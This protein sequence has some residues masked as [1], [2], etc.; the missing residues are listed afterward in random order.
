VEADEVIE[1]KVRKVLERAPD[2]PSPGEVA[3]YAA[4]SP[5]GFFIIC[6]GIGILCLGALALAYAAT[7]VGWSL[8]G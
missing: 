5:E 8:I 6:L 4:K 7:M 3:R 1:A 2:L